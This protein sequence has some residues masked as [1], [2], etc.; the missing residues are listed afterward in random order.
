MFS[1]D[2]LSLELGPN[3]DDSYEPGPYNDGAGPVATAA[4]GADVDLIA[5][6]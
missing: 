5:P 3:F 2:T 4:D 1:T 6:F